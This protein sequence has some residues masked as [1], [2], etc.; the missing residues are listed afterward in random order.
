MNLIHVAAL[1]ACANEIYLYVN[2]LTEENKKCIK[3]KH[4]KELVRLGIINFAI[5]NNNIEL[6]QYLIENNYITNDYALILASLI[7]RLKIVTLLLAKS[8]PEA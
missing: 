7:D 4:L 6:L 3:D 2:N 5:T 8:G 1:V